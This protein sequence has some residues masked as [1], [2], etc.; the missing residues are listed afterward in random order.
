MIEDDAEYTGIFAYWTGSD[1]IA[2]LTTYRASDI[3]GAQVRVKS[4][5]FTEYV[6]GESFTVNVPVEPRRAASGLIFYAESC[7]NVIAP[8]NKRVRSAR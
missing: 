2:P 1:A 6:L 4:P 8:R 5:P 3:L 7:R